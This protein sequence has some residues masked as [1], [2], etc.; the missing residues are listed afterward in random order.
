MRFH[1]PD[2]HSHTRNGLNSHSLVSAHHHTGCF[3]ECVCVRAIHVHIF[4]CRFFFFRSLAVSNLCTFGI[5]SM[6]ATLP[7]VSFLFRLGLCHALLHQL[8]GRR[9]MMMVKL[10]IDF[11][12]QCFRQR[13]DAMWWLQSRN[14]AVENHSHYS[15]TKHNFNRSSIRDV[16]VQ[17]RTATTSI[18][19]FEL[20]RRGIL[21]IKQWM[22]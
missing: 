11:N 17:N 9:M 19:P 12:V 8:C 7:C 2:T 22:K 1:S 3:R 5:F 4:K 15:Y 20:Q 6:V 18:A 14:A 13:N 16:I 21:S 10:T